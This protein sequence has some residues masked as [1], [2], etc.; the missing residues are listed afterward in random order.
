MEKIAL[1][2]RSFDEFQLP[3]E[4]PFPPNRLF[5]GREDLIDRIHTIFHPAKSA[6]DVTSPIST[7]RQLIAL[8]GLGGIGKTQ[9]ALEYAHRYE[10]FYSTILWVDA[11][12]RTVLE[13]SGVR[14]LQQLVCHY[15]TRSPSNPD[16]IRIASEL[17]IPG[18]IDPSGAIRQ[19][20]VNSNSVWRGIKQWL[21]KKGN[22]RWLLLVDNN[23][24]LEAVNILDYLPTSNWGSIIVT[25]RRSD[26]QSLGHS[27]SVMEMEKDIGRVLLT[28][29]MRGDGEELSG[30]GKYDRTVLNF[31]PC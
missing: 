12:D 26:I 24:D 1:N 17:G 10:Q 22:V 11:K 28:K 30:T 8:H 9:I 15:A 4:L 5:C 13:S 20:T 7:A 29:A 27:I 31:C 21:Q 2:E 19:E 23:D 14:I 3:A 16:Y 25:S 18:G 6:T